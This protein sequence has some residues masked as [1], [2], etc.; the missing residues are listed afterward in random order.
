MI[1]VILVALYHFND[2]WLHQ[3][4]LFM[5]NVKMELIGLSEIMK[6]IDGTKQAE[7]ERPRK[8]WWDCD[9]VKGYV[10]DSGLSRKDA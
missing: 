5:L 2:S 3:K 7:R 1:T 6:K 4:L 9:R 10:K 8:T